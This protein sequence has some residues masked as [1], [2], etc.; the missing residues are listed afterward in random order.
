MSQ[1]AASSITWLETSSVVPAVGEPVEEVPQ[2]APQH[3]VQSDRRLVKNE[4]LRVVEQR[5][6]ERDASPLAARERSDDLVACFRQAYPPQDGLDATWTDVNEPR[7]V[8]EILANREVP[9][10]RTAPA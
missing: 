7:E 3:R 1:R 2:I 10:R 5:G 9:R 4:E 6:R 8:P